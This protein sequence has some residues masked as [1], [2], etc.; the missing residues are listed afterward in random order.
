MAIPPPHLHWK[1]K[2]REQASKPASGVVPAANTGVENRPATVVPQPALAR[3]G[4][5][6]IFRDQFALR[7]S[8]R[9]PD[10]PGLNCT[11]FAPPGR[12]GIGGTRYLSARRRESIIRREP[13][14]SQTHAR[15]V[16]ERLAIG[17]D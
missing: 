9:K 14:G 1:S 17:I 6:R 15:C 3:M 5:A 13:T 16:S 12:P 8:R 10:S 4:R 11:Y 7:S 2:S